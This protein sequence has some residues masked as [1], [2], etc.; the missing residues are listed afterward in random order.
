MSTSVKKVSPNVVVMPRALTLQVATNVPV[1]LGTLEMDS[2][3]RV[4]HVSLTK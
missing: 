4:S 2:T 3:A 1:N